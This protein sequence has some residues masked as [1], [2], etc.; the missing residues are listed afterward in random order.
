LFDQPI[1]DSLL[2]T[3]ER[4]ANVRVFE[5]WKGLGKEIP[6]LGWEANGR[7]AVNL[8]LTA[9]GLDPLSADALFR[10]SVNETA[11]GTQF[12]LF[13]AKGTAVPVQEAFFRTANE[14]ENPV[15]DMQSL[16]YATRHEQPDSGSEQT[17]FDRVA[18]FPS[19]SQPQPRIGQLFAGIQTLVFDSSDDPFRI[20]GDVTDIREVVWYG[21]GERELLEAPFQPGLYGYETS[22]QVV[23]TLFRTRTTDEPGD[24]QHLFGNAERLG[25]RELETGFYD[26][27]GSRAS[28]IDRLA[29]L[30]EGPPSGQ[31][32]LDSQTLSAGVVTAFASTDGD[33]L[34]Q[35]RFAV[36][37]VYLLS[38]FCNDVPFVTGPVYSALAEVDFGNAELTFTLPSDLSERASRLPDCEALIGRFVAIS[39]DAL[40]NTSENQSAP[41]FRTSS[42][43]LGSLRDSPLGF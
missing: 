27:S 33:D 22:T 7:Q 21:G 10:V 32:L 5:D 39:F 6:I 11:P 12:E 8:G 41:I 25:F 16:A 38:G 13:A 18:A 40:D 30:F 23:E 24:P 2:L 15:P 9:N 31:V 29:Y 26:E 43:G 20:A 17:S 28:A 36:F 19:S 3:E 37:E 42:R 1:Q 4:R 35:L 14:A 34:S